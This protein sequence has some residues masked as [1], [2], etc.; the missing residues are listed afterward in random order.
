M[1]NKYYYIKKITTTMTNANKQQTWCDL[2]EIA[3]LSHMLLCVSYIKMKIKRTNSKENKNDKLKAV[4]NCIHWIC[5]LWKSFNNS[6][7][8][9]QIDLCVLSM[10]TE[11]LWSF[12]RVLCQTNS[13]VSLSKYQQIPTLCL[14]FHEHTSISMLTFSF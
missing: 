12:P 11:L 1:V 3:I 9:S 14:Q 7:L 13:M 8:N 2:H 4:Q 6:C 5:Y 10:S